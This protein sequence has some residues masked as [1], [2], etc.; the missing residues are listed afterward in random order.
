MDVPESK[1]PP[2][3][4]HGQAMRWQQR[5]AALTRE[6]ILDAAVDCL[7]ERGYTG[8]TTIEVTRRAG[9]SRGAMHHHF[10]TRMEMVAA[11]IDHVLTLRLDRFLKDY[12]ASLER[13]PDEDVIAVASELHWQ[14]MLTPEFAAYLELTMVART[15]RK[16]ADLLVPATVA[17]DREWLRAMTEAFPQWQGNPEALLL[18]NDLTVAVHV[19]LLVNRP[20]IGDR[21]RRA[22][23]RSKLIEVLREIHGEGQP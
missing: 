16:L 10:A 21:E 2:A 1:N 22:A 13:D 4:E 7:V 19:G 18:A 12:L 6:A 11:L 23:V 3:E 9:I 5:K 8:L 20:Y 17:S 14:A 15:D